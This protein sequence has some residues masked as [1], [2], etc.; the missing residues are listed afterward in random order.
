[1]TT[2]LLLSS[3]ARISDREWPSGC[4]L[5]HQREFHLQSFSQEIQILRQPGGEIAGLIGP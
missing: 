1:M 4:F 3:S 2:G 5:L